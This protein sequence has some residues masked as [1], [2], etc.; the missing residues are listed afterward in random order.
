MSRSHGRIRTCEW[1]EL[2][3]V[4]SL[5]KECG[6]YYDFIDYDEGLRRKLNHDPDS[7]L[8]LEFRRSIVAAVVMIY[9]PWASFLFHLVVKPKYQGRGFGSR[10]LDE[11]ENRLRFR[12]TGLIAAYILPGNTRSLSMCK[13]RGYQVY[14]QRAICVDKPLKFQDK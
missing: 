4:I 5:F 12:G 9:D 6:L 7:I 1:H 14:P 2:P 3:R 8:V 13:K 11:A 10:L